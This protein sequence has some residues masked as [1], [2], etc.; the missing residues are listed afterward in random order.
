[1]PTANFCSCANVP[2]VSVK[3]INVVIVVI[4]V[5]ISVKFRGL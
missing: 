1:L 4:V 2:S 5:F 3:A